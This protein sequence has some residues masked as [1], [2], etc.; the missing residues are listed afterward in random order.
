VKSGER[1]MKTREGFISEVIEAIKFAEKSTLLDNNA[2]ERDNGRAA[3]EKLH[4]DFP[5][6]TAPC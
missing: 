2:L 5:V 6:S 4:F 1:E 3:F